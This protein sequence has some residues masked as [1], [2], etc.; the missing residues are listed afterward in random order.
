LSQ[1]RMVTRLVWKAGI[2]LSV[3]L[4]MLIGT[5]LAV[6]IGESQTLSRELLRLKASGFSFLL[7]KSFERI[8]DGEI[9]ANAFWERQIRQSITATS[10]E[11]GAVIG[12][13]LPE[14]GLIAVAVNAE[15][16]P[17]YQMQP[18]Q[19]A[20]TP[21]FAYHQR[22]A[23][24]GRA[25][26]IMGRFPWQEKLMLTHIEPLI[27]G[28]QRLGEIVVAYPLAKFI[29]LQRRT[30]Y[31]FVGLLLVFIVN[32]VIIIS[33]WVHGLRRNLEFLYLSLENSRE[34]NEDPPDCIYHEFWQV[35]QWNMAITAQLQ[36]SIQ[37]QS[38]LFQNSPCGIMILSPEG[39]ILETNTG[40]WELLQRINHRD[41]SKITSI[42]SNFN[43]AMEIILDGQT[44]TGEIS[45]LHGEEEIT[46]IYAMAPIQTASWKGAVMFWLDQTEVKRLGVRLRLTERYQLV[47]ELASIAAHELRN[48]L[49]TI[50]ANAQLG[51]IVADADKRKELFVR[52]QQASHR[53]SD[54]L[55]DMMNL[56]R[57]DETELIPVDVDS[58]I[59][60]VLNMVR[61]QLLT[62]GIELELRIQD[63]LPRIWGENRLLRQVLLNLIQNAIQAMLNGGRLFVKAYPTANEVIVVI[64]DSGEGIPAKLQGQIF[65]SFVTSKEQGNGLGLF[66]TR[67]IMVQSFGGRIWFS[68]NP[69]EGAEFFLAFPLSEPLSPV[70][71]TRSQKAYW[72]E[73]QSVVQ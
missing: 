57:P 40:A 59:S 68:S 67:Q 37:L 16:N 23:W 51:L 27:I 20:F 49:T 11:P 71:A 72:T 29:H 24:S 31:L 64:Q 38:T 60:D 5:L 55:K 7:N 46:L 19:E 63:G 54:F 22:D 61:A 13:R 3:L 35:A 1:Q 36:E 32:S 21:V 47:G 43:K 56:C 66:I 10:L 18:S 34:I 17:L 45:L 8:S 62:Q 70:S 25:P 26:I 73:K 52:I 28:T 6:I 30:I 44:Y 39:E 12:I 41:T 14:I 42:S 65:K 9:V 15:N 50:I 69:G 48:P 33:R 58:A 4:L 2:S 53:M